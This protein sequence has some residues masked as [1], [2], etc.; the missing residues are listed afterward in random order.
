MRNISL[1]F[2]YMCVSESEGTFIP[3]QLKLFVVPKQILKNIQSQKY[4]YGWM[5]IFT[6]LSENNLT[7]TV[8]VMKHFQ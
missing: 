3:S 5:C 4:L 7:S 8:N 2:K 1:F 6:Y